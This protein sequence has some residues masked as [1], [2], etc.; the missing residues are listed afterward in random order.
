MRPIRNIVYSVFFVLM[1]LGG[2]AADTNSSLAR[3]DTS[4]EVKPARVTAV[5]GVTAEDYLPVQSAPTVQYTSQVRE[6]HSRTAFKLPDSF[7]FA[8]VPIFIFLLLYVI[9]I[10]LRDFEDRQ[11]ELRRQGV[12]RSTDVD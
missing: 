12:S 8:A 11:E 10:F 2:I 3:L 4:G 9:M 7:Y 6:S 5:Y 1:A